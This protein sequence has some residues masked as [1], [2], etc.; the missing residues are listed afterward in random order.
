[1]ENDTQNYFVLNQFSELWK[2][3]SLFSDKGYV[4]LP[5]GASIGLKKRLKIPL[6]LVGFDTNLLK[7]GKTST[8]DINP[9][10]SFDLDE[11]DMFYVLEKDS[12][13]IRRLSIY[14]YEHAD[15]SFST[16]RLLSDEYIAVYKDLGIVNSLSVSG[17]HI[18]VLENSA[19]YAVSKVNYELIK[20][21]NFND[22]V[23]IFKI[24]KD[25]Q[26]VFY[27]Y[28]NDKT[29]LFKKDLAWKK[30]SSHDNDEK[31]VQI[32]D[33]NKN[34]LLDQ[35]SVDNE[36]NNGHWSE[37]SRNNTRDKRYRNH[38]NHR[39]SSNYYSE[40]DK[41]LRNIIDI[42]INNKLKLLYVLTYRD[43]Y[44]YDFEGNQ[45]CEP[46]ALRG[47][48]GEEFNP[49]SL[50]IDENDNDVFIGNTTKAP[51]LAFPIK[52]ENVFSRKENEKKPRLEKI[53]FQGQSRRLFLTTVAKGGKSYRRLL[54]VNILGESNQNG[55]NINGDTINSNRN[56][57][58]LGEAGRSRDISAYIACEI[59]EES[60]I[61]EIESLMTLTS[62]S[63]DSLD[64]N[65]RWY[66]IT[67]DLDTP[68]NTFVK[69]S[70]F[71]T[72]D[73]MLENEIYEWK[74]GPVNSKSVLILDCVGRYLVLKVELSSLDEK[75]SPRFS[76]MTVHFSVPTY[77]RYLPDIY[78]E[79]E[80]SKIF[81]EKFLS[82]FQ[83]LFEDTQNKIFSFVKHLDVRTTP[84]AFLPWLSSWIS[85]GHREGW[86]SE[87]LRS[88]LESAPEL[89]RKRG[90]KKGL[91]EIL[92]IYLQD[93]EIKDLEKISRSERSMIE[94]DI[95]AKGTINSIKSQDHIAGAGRTFFILEG[96][97]ELNELLNILDE[98]FDK[99]KFQDVLPFC[100][101]VLLNPFQ[102]DENKA[103]I[104]KMIV[105][106]E[107]PAHTVG[108]VR[109]L[110][111]W[112]ILGKDNFLGVNTVIRD[113]NSFILG[114]SCLGI[115]G[116]F[117]SPQEYN[118]DLI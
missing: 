53:G 118:L 42:A 35:A 59:L 104:I 81:L 49:T 5:Q 73:E 44:V 86:S 11:Y 115:D 36:Q 7:T 30:A 20:T 10:F 1:M 40:T 37:E 48:D 96:K 14:D 101:Y 71:C 67:M 23:D 12:K 45:V 25:E 77:L 103:H 52:L 80:Q 56:K 51:Q 32:V 98:R 94:N 117:V 58:N 69:L 60:P 109:R 13:K 33:L 24:T 50:A 27:S 26:V 70:Y 87:S 100:F 113:R 85:I 114:K 19:L 8:D 83:T 88:L 91:E 38:S 110:P 90:T 108:I 82:I 93:I 41:I 21:I 28:A 97:S 95:L 18:Y 116:L 99:A 63:L 31:E 3:R 79:D 47:D 16:E 64:E 62:Q 76:K 84:D 78:Q 15:E 54:L 105:E 9:L 65:T 22:N 61:Y 89:F 92:S 2:D 75:A 66:K 39:P 46:V 106:N 112:S 68:P 74:S 6:R 17:K 72:N 111:E 29:V 107:K 34:I 43:L 4:S 55:N 102:V 57:D